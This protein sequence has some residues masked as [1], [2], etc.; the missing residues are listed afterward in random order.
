MAFNTALS[1]LRAANADLSVIGHNIANASTVGFKASRAEFA[2]VYANSILGSGRLSIG[3]GALLADVTQQFGQGNITFTN[4]VLDLSIN[5]NG[6]F[7]MEE[8]GAVS[9]G[10]AG[11]FQLDNQGFMVSNQGKRLQGFTADASGNINGVSDDLQINVQTQPPQQTTEVSGEFN[12]DAGELPVPFGA[13]SSAGIQVGVA[14]SG[15]DN[16]YAAE[17]IR[18]TAIDGTTNDLVIPRPAGGPGTEAS[19]I[20]SLA[21]AIPG[22]SAGATAQATL[23]SITIPNASTLTLN[24]QVIGGQNAT[25]NS[26]ANTIN[27]LAGTGSLPGY[28]AVSAGGQVTVTNESGDDLQ[29]VLSGAAGD[30]VTVTGVDTAAT[31]VTISGS[32]TSTVGGTVTL[33]MDEDLSAQFTVGGNNI[34]AVDPL[35]AGYVR[36]TRSFDPADPTTYNHAT[37]LTV[38]DSL[39]SSH[40]MTQYFVKESDLDVGVTNTWRMYVQI[41]GQDVG[42]PNTAAA[43]AGAATPANFRLFFNAD[44]SLDQNQ[45]DQILISNWTP[46]DAAGNPTGALGPQN[47][48]NGGSAMI[49]DPPISS[50]FVVDLTGTTQ[51]GSLFAV[52][53]VSQ[54]G[55]AVGRLAGVEIGGSGIIFARFT[56]G[57]SQTLGQIALADFA[58]QQGLAP[59]GDTE[60]TETFESGGAVIGAPGSA[61]LGTIQSGALEES[62]T[63]L[64][65]ELVK[66]IIAQRNFQANAQTIQT[67]D[68]VTQ[69]IINIR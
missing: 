68:A 37:A 5:G 58:N 32:G 57:Q 39:G 42:D 56:N 29:F 2:D 34:F 7:V 47:V 43:D 28:S 24:G 11:Q 21:N 33:A 22:V 18:F 61:A 49:P 38:F 66:L 54:N 13:R 60:W 69:T 63:E 19:A 35:N 40:V 52:N 1:G 12:L 23:S 10:R 30:A 4:N 48:V 6:F 36:T 26:I 9:Y 53:D 25:A 16:G 65:E 46:L 17:T 20:A 55:F 31:A 8:G 3:S 27:A 44:G 15:T 50:N 45:S 41:D 64:S 14:R 62:T 51:F 67:A 59:A